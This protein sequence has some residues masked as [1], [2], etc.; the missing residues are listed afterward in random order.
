MIGSDGELYKSVQ[1]SGGSLTSQDPTTDSSDTYW[2]AFAISVANSST[3]ARGIIRTATTAEA[4]DRDGHLASGDAGRARRGDCGGSPGIN[5]RNG[6]CTG[7]LHGG[8][9]TTT[10]AWRCGR[11]RTARVTVNAVGAALRAVFNR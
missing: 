11:R 4:R 2:E 9:Q 5:V 7:A 10:F 6:R 8:R 1:A 3:T